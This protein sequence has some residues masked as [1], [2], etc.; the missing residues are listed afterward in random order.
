MP[1]PSPSKWLLMAVAP[2]AVILHILLVGC[3]LRARRSFSAEVPREPCARRNVEESKYA[4]P[5]DNGK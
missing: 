5:V 1:I 2:G 3:V 4:R